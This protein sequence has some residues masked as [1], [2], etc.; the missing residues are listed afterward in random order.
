MA[1]IPR[2]QALENALVSSRMEGY[3]VTEQTRA[4]CRRSGT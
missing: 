2:E 4:N 1:P 3:E